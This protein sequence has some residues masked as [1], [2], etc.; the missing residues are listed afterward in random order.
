MPEGIRVPLDAKPFAAHRVAIG[1]VASGARTSGEGS[2][3]AARE[4]SFARPDEIARFCRF[5]GPALPPAPTEFCPRGRKRGN[6][7]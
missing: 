3:G 6:S 1:T 2:D 5:S 7:S 4:T